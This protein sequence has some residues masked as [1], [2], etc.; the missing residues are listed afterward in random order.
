MLCFEQA[1]RIIPHLKTR[2]GK[3]LS[4]NHKTPEVR[5]LHDVWDAVISK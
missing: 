2:I 1:G 5:C 4:T 3:L